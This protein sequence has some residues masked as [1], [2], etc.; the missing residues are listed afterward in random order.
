MRGFV[1]HHTIMALK[2]IFALEG[3]PRTIVSDNGPQFGSTEFQN[4]FA[5]IAI[6][7]VF[8]PSYHPESNGLAERFIQSFKR[9]FLNVWAQYVVPNIIRAER[10]LSVSLERCL[11]F[12]NCHRCKLLLT[13]GG[14]S[15]PTY[16]FLGQRMHVLKLLQAVVAKGNDMVM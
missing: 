6:R 2:S 1:T 15:K 10:L 4:F 5:T 14:R 12:Y 7:E 13:Y 3:I 8:S 9:S 11:F 16:V